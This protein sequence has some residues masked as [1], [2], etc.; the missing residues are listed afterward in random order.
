[1]VKEVEGGGCN[2]YEIQRNK[3]VAENKAKL[4][5]LRLCQ[6]KSASEKEKYKATKPNGN[7]G[8]SDYCPSNDEEAVEQQSEGAEDYIGTSKVCLYH[9]VIL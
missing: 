9:P 8:E 1:M 6:T 3:N 5:A 7:V 4:K 2:D